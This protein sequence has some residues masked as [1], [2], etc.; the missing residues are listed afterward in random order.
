M[1]MIDTLTDEQLQF[2]SSAIDK[3][4]AELCRVNQCGGEFP[5]RASQFLMPKER[6]AIATLALAMDGPDEADR[7]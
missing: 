2:V 1:S 4:E 3:M 6:H 5:R 7:T